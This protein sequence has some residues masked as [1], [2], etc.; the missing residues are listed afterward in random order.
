MTPAAL[1]H[2]IVP[3][4]PSSPGS[5]YSSNAGAPPPTIYGP[6][7]IPKDSEKPKPNLAC[8]FCRTRKI[9]C[10]A[11]PLDADD[12]TCNQCKRRHLTCTYPE[13]SRRGMRQPGSV[14]KKRKSS[15]AASGPTDCSDPIP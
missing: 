6:R 5:Y 1:A 11:P 15:K 14:P 13:K 12:R 7:R 9:A 4:M 2:P 8:L 3:S 10:S